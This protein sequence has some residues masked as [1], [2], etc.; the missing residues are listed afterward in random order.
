LLLL[1]LV[2]VII[3]D[4]LDE[5]SCDG[6]NR[7]LGIVGQNILLPLNRSKSNRKTILFV[8]AVKLLL[9]VILVLGVSRLRCLLRFCDCPSLRHSTSSG[10]STFSFAPLADVIYHLLPPTPEMLRI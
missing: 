2:T 8:A 10:T 9:T 3:N 6:T 7:P 1:L 5:L 4:I